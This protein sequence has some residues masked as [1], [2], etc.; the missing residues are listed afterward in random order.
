MLKQRFYTA[1]L[2]IPAIIFAT[3]WLNTGGFALILAV[4]I[5]LG[6]WEWIGLSGYHNTIG[7]IAFVILVLSMLAI[8]F[9][10]RAT[11][12]SALLIS[13]ASVWWLVATM[14]VVIQQRRMHLNLGG[15]YVKAII[16][17][18][19]LVPSWLSLVLLHGDHDYGQ[20]YVIFLLALIWLA[21]GAA[22]FSGHRWGTTKLASLV[23]PGKTWAGVLG[24]ILASTLASVI[25]A[26]ATGMQPPDI[27]IFSFICCITVMG[28]IV[29]DLIES[30][31]KRLGNVKDSGAIF[32]GHGGVMD[33]IDSLTAAAPIFITGLW[34][35][36]ELR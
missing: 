11:L 24:A 32:P 14:L 4:F 7:R 35:T 30:L 2:L 1:F 31:L 28:S 36:Q 20:L 3:V 19:V 29:G 33:R 22:Y 26:L 12:L 8:C 21:D 18:A 13:L 16:G 27:I 17:F 15:N 6:A 5:G 34:L 10:F 25:F 23:S 9:I